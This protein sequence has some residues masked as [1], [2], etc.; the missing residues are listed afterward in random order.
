LLDVAVF[1]HPSSSIAAFA[2]VGMITLDDLT[3]LASE[4]ELAGGLTTAADV[5]RPPTALREHDTPRTAYDRMASSGL[6]EL[7]VV[8]AGRRVVGLVNEVAIARADLQ[9]R[10]RPALAAPEQ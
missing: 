9:A 3:V 10:H 8:D 4:P 7:P 1:G 5:M 2:L 6:R